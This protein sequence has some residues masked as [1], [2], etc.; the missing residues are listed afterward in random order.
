MATKCA[1]SSLGLSSN[2]SSRLCFFLECSTGL[3]KATLLT[4]IQEKKMKTSWL[5]SRLPCKQSLISEIVKLLQPVIPSFNKQV[6]AL[7]CSDLS[8]N[9]QIRHY[10]YSK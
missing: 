8:K 2:L 10:I 1:K 7:K 6:T 9:L 5:S 3:R 4:T